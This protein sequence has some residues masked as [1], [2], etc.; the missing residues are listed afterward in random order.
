[1]ESQL[2][3]N[4]PK[5]NQYISSKL[6]QKNAELF[7]MENAQIYIKDQLILDSINLKI[8]RGDLFFVTGPTGAGKST[9]LNVLS[10][11]KKPY[12]V[13]G[14]MRRNL[15][16]NNRQLFVSR[17]FQD[18]KIFKHQTIFEN[19]YYA[20]D[21]KIY[22]T[23]K[24]F[25]MQL[26]DYCKIFGLEKM[27][28]RRLTEVNGGVKQKV[29][30]IRSLLCK[31]DVVIADEPTSSLDKKSAMKVFDVLSLLNNKKGLTVIWATH[32]K[33][34]IK[35]FHGKIIHIDAGKIVYNGKACFI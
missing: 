32:N 21:Q 17:I 14:N 19:L 26:M 22:N 13:L 33:E 31:P 2:Y 4:I 8:N 10:G 34:L 30:I 28:S 3:R 27:L 11:E 16:A 20:Y 5:R 18:L 23:E 15:Q 1:M 35:N 24:D 25:S 29:A 6:H 12:R 7:F 9:L